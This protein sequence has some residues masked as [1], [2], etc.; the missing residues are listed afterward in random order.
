MGHR[1]GHDVG[2]VIIGQRVL[3]LPAP[4]RSGHHAGAAQ[5]AQM[6][7]DQRLRHRERLDE[8]VHAACTR[9]QLGHDR[10]PQR[11][12]ERSEQFSR[13]GVIPVGIHRS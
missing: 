5:H 12:G 8:F 9:A 6:L 1:V 13:G 2:D 4:A 10:D 7:R 3:R 11:R